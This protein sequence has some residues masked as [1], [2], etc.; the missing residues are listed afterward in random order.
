MYQQ[1]LARRAAPLN[2]TVNIRVLQ[3]AWKKV[4]DYYAILR[5]V[6]IPSSLR[7]GQH[8]QAVLSSYSADILVITCGDEKD[9]LCRIKSH[10]SLDCHD[11]TTSEK[12]PH[13][14][15][16]LFTTAD[17]QKTA[18][19]LEISHALID[20]MSVSVLFRDL[21]SAYRGRLATKQGSELYS[22]DY[23]TWLTRQ[24]TCDS[25]EYWR[26]LIASS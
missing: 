14:R 2:G 18:C 12:R 13:Y 3:E 9:L 19:K 24:T 11:Q 7:P 15:F 8:D 5:T 23:V 22:G 10:K 20:G 17:A 1:V 21:A 26:Q 4:L 16:T 6:F 25:V